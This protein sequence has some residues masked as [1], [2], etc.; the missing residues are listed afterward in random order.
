[1][2]TACDHILGKLNINV[3]Y[4]ATCLR[5][6]GVWSPVGGKKRGGVVLKEGGGGKVVG[7]LDVD[8]VATAYYRLLAYRN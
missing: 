5:V 2:N 6:G 7:C 4:K 1:M 8:S 3:H